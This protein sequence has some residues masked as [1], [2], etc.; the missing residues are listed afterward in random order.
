M[1]SVDQN[2]PTSAEN[3]KSI[4]LLLA[5]FPVILL[6]FMLGAS[7]YYFADNSSYGGNQIGLLIA[8]AVAAMIGIKLGHKWG[9][10]EKGI[11]DGISNAMIA[12][13][14]LLMVGALIGSWML[15]G[16]VQSLIYYGLM[17][18]SAEW[19]YA[20]ACLVCGIAAMSI[21][22]SWTVAGTL[23]VAFMGMAAAMQLDP[24][25]TAGAV[26]SGAYF[27]DKLSPLSDTTNLASAVADTP[28]FL[29]IRNLLWTTVPSFVV[30][31]TLFAFM[32]GEQTLASLQSIEETMI[33]L[34]ANFTI[35]L[36]LLLPVVFVFI[37]AWLQVPAL[38][39]IFAGALLGGAFAVFFQPQ[40]DQDGLANNKQ[41][42]LGNLV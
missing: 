6:M 17:L 34:D 29:H 24:A 23:G 21:G 25:I 4:P 10:I 26:I 22:S 9:D 11:I 38:P 33:G 1:S 14:I 41:K 20:A 3:Y 42:T 12:V 31:L 2:V 18:I 5:V 32:G 37:L 7:V 35:G 8:A 36:H 13:L 15:S 40:F 39:T 16:T 27:G 19:F 28:L 30:A